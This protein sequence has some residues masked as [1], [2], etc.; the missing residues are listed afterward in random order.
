MV[1][2]EFEKIDQPIKPTDHQVQRSSLRN[3]VPE[4]LREITV[5]ARRDHPDKR[6]NG[7]RLE[8]VRDGAGDKHYNVT[9]FFCDDRPALNPHNL[10]NVEQM[11]FG[12]VLDAEEMA[13]YGVGIGREWK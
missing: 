1:V 7:Y 4:M 8:I 5:E 2:F 12:Q 11:A 10:N 9:A 3:I 13:K 6:F